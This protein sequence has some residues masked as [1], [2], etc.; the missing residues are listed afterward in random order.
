MNS[1]THI[2]GKELSELNCLHFDLIFDKPRSQCLIFHP[3]LPNYLFFCINILGVT[4]FRSF[5]YLFIFV[6]ILSTF[7]Y[8]F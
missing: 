2:L 5:F 3:D 7:M 8:L 4:F 6:T 1:R